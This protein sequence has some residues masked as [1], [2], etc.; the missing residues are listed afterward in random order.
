MRRQENSELCITGSCSAQVHT[1]CRG[2]LG[3][4]EK[5]DEDKP[6]HSAVHVLTC[7]PVFLLTCRLSW[8]TSTSPKSIFK[9]QICAYVD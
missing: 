4:C 3:M 6:I 9:L 5:H 1:V 8:I 2:H 7:V